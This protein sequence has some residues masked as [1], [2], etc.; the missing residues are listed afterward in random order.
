MRTKIIA[1]EVMKD[2][3]LS[4]PGMC[5]M[6]ISFITMGLHLN[7]GKLN[8]ELQRQLDSLEGYTHIVLAFGLCGGA[9]RTLKSKDSTI[10]IPRVH[11]C[12]PLLLGSVKAYESFRSKEPGTFYYSCG[13]FKGN[14]TFFSDYEG[15]SE[16]CGEEDALEIMKEMYDGYKNIVFIRTGHPHEELCIEKC[17]EIAKL[18]DLCFITYEGKKC[19]I[20]KLVKGPWNDDEFIILGPGQDLNDSYFN[21]TTV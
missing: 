4:V 20:E 18:L 2:E 1:C 12:I 21:I 10:I 6:D 14:S 5:D 8:V 9:A 16:K 11:D 13:W 7:P 15:L 17:K 19:Y 3:I